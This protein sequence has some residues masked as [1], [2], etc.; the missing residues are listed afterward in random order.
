[1]FIGLSFI[2]SSVKDCGGAVNHGTGCEYSKEN[3]RCFA[4]AKDCDH[5]DKEDGRNDE[6][7][8]IHFKPPSKL[9]RTFS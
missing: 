2:G 6:D 3:P 4:P 1:M 5:C 9:I 7:G 8:G